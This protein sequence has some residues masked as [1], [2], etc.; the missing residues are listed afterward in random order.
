M[1]GFLEA[2]TITEIPVIT[3]VALETQP[4]P[5]Q[6][7]ACLH[8]CQFYSVATQL[9]EEPVFVM[10]PRG[11]IDTKN[12]QIMFNVLNWAYL[13][14]K[15]FE[16]THYSSDKHLDDLEPV[17]RL[18]DPTKQALSQNIKRQMSYGPDTLCIPI[19][20]PDSNGRLIDWVILSDH[21]S[22]GEIATN[23]GV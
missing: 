4:L 23:W 1:F 16:V 5:A 2:R 12:G 8:G 7:V 18:C 13:Q 20:A 10:A 17:I 21:P 22:F 6:E 19:L 11:S 15:Y 9:T 3:P 14:A